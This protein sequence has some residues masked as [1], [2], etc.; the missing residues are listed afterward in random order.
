MGPKDRFAEL[1]VR[2]GAMRVLRRVAPARLVVFCYHRIRPET[3][4]FS[5]VF[6]DDVFGPT[7]LQF[8]EQMRWLRQHT[9]ILSEADLLAR[10]DAPRP[11]SEPCVAVTF[12]DGYRDN[13]TFGLPVLEEFGIPAVFFIPTDLIDKRRLGWWDL[14]SY[15]LR[16]TQR[17]TIR[18]DGRQYV[19]GSRRG[20]VVASLLERMKR[21][22]ARETET[23]LTDLSEAC[24]VPFPGAAVQDAELMTWEQIRE[25]A[26]RGITIGSHSRTHRVLTTLDQTT[27]TEELGTSKQALERMVG[28]EVRSIA[29]PCGGPESFDSNVQHAARA[30]GYELGFSFSQEANRSERLVP[31]DVRRIGAPPGVSRLSAITVLPQIFAF[32][33]APRT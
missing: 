33:S 13:Y 6:D 22:P 5:T 17:P 3:P 12:D 28:R 19:L 15:F 2:S 11:L 9:T 23:L 30:A 27:L 10:A 7:V 31:F 1:L 29:Y 14:I 26:E 24:A 25:A 20:E 21:A 16:Q 32:S 8:R 18:L 4:G